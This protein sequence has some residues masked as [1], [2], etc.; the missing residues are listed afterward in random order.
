MTLTVANIVE[1]VETRDMT[2]EDNSKKNP[3]EAAD[4]NN[5]EEKENIC[6]N[7]TVA[8]NSKKRST[9]NKKDNSVGLIKRKAAPNANGDNNGKRKKPNI[10]QSLSRSLNEENNSDPELTEDVEECTNR[11]E[12]S[13]EFAAKEVKKRVKSKKEETAATDRSLTNEDIDEDC[14]R[15]FWQQDRGYIKEINNFMKE[16]GLDLKAFPPTKGDGNCWFR[17]VSDQVVIQ[18]IPNKAKNHRALRLEVCDHVK[19]LPEDIRETTIALVFSGKKRVLNEMVTR[20]GRRGSG[21]TTPA[22]WC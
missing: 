4:I 12:V 16:T 6:E 14:D 18:N 9:K 19:M 5:E 10:V 17:A 21:W 1:K 22:S 3:P 11:S 20:Q 13:D 8:D 15:K 2:S 7:L